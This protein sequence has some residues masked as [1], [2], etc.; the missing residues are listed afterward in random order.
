MDKK[1]AQIER[2]VGSVGLRKIEQQ[3]SECVFLLS[4]IF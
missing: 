2:N 1:I 4:R 3:C